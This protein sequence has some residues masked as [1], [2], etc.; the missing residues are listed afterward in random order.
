MRLLKKCIVGFVAQ[1]FYDLKQ[2]NMTESTNQVV[3]R[4]FCRRN[5]E[6]V[7]S[8]YEKLVRS[9]SRRFRFGSRARNVAVKPS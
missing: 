5:F 4:Y 6:W 8:T 2:T 7:T 3:R 9:V 1:I